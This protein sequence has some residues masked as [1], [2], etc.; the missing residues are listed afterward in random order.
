M[1]LDLHEATSRRRAG[2]VDRLT[3]D[4]VLTDKLLRGALLRLPREVPAPARVRPGQRP[5]RGPDRLAPPRR[6]P[7][8]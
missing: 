8:R 6:L 2:M 1:P 4:G 3:T 5:G 7:P